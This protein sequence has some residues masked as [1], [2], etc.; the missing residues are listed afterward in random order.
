MN[1]RLVGVLAALEVRLRLR[2][3]STLAAVLAVMAV[4]WAMIADPASGKSL[5]VLD[6]ARVLYTSSALALGSATMAGILFGLA[7]FFLVRGRAGEDLRSGIG[8]VIGATPAASA[9]MLAGRWLGGVAYLGLLVLAFM[10]TMLACHLVRGEG[11]VQLGVY[12]QTYALLLGPMVLFAASC[13]LLFDSWAPLMGKA[14][15]LIYFVLWLFLLGLGPQMEQQGAHPDLLSAPALLDVM[16]LGH[17]IAGL[18]A[19]LD[20]RGMGIGSTPFDPALPLRELPQ[21]LWNK[22]IVLGRALSALIALLPAIP[23]VFLFH[24]FSP[25]RVKAGKARARRT[26]LALL[27]GWL[28][29]LARAVQPLFGLAAR[30]PG[31]AGQALADAALALATAPSAIAALGAALVAGIVLPAQALPGLVLACVA[32]WGVFVS[33]TATRDL[34]AGCEDLGAAVP[35]GAAR[36]F[37]RQ[38]LAAIL[39]GWM[40]M[41]LPALRWLPETPV[42]SLAVFG[43][44]AALAAFAAL[45][46]RLSRTPRLF[47]GLFLFGLYVA[48]N[49][50]SVPLLDVVGFNGAATMQSA[51]I[52]LASGLA[53]FAA[54]LAW[55]RRGG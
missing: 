29:P 39:L 48:V 14:G 43:G 6:G 50:R 12:L 52:I 20:T 24:R 26:P 34:N 53:A 40:F 30:T 28:R 21:W 11:P 10:A 23:A 32:F 49:A 38:A 47:L 13:A 18:S 35:G 33:D 37:L 16:G 8:G 27:N 5:V 9:A 3:L 55:N 44:V 31:L 51:A 25:D 1:A 17:A 15:D 41:G 42:R 2:R 22:T 54:G 19:H 36:R 45:L 46:G 7:G 4:S